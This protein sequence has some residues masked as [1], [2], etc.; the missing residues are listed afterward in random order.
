MFRLADSHQ[1]TYVTYRRE[2]EY[3]RGANK[4]IR[5]RSSVPI[6]DQPAAVIVGNF[7][8]VDDA[9]ELVQLSPARSELRRLYHQ[10]LR[11][12]IEK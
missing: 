5:V 1:N 2:T 9:P 12:A 7:A 6:E 10:K 3:C 4:G 11:H 8:R